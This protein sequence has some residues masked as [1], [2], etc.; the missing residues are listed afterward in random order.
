V[1]LPLPADVVARAADAPRPTTLPPPTK[2][3][4]SPMVLY[5]VIGVIVLGGLGTAAFFAFW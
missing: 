5:V 3:G 1:G 2:S 4:G